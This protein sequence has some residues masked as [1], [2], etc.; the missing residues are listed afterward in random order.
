MKMPGECGFGRDDAQRRDDA[1]AG[2]SRSCRHSWPRIARWRPFGT[3]AMAPALEIFDAGII[4]RFRSRRRR[5]RG[6]LSLGAVD[7]GIS[8]RSAGGDCLYFI[9]LRH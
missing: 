2:N 7:N 6:A 1:G 9:E 8:R 5:C 4:D 3:L